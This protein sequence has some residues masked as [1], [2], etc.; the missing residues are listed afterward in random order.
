MYKNLHFFLIL[1][2]RYFICPWTVPLFVL[3]RF[4]ILLSFSPWYCNNNAFLALTPQSA[5]LTI[6][7][8]PRPQKGSGR[9]QL[10][11]TRASHCVGGGVAWGPKSNRNWK[12][13]LNDK[14][15]ALGL[16]SAFTLKDKNNSLYVLNDAKIAKPSAKT[17]AT[18]LSGLKLT[19]KKVLIVA[20]DNKNL[21]MS[22][23][24]IN[25]VEAKN[26]NQVSTKDVLNASYVILEKAAIENIGKVV[27]I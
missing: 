11:S 17:V 25:R 20:N 1:F 12:I 4:A 26:W 13:S 27:N 24:N 19:N 22:A 23:K 3:I 14:T 10:G 7:K 2:L 5:S 6:F 8:K 21:I 16:K 9:A 18:M 15:A